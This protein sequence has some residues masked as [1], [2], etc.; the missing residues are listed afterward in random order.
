MHPKGFEMIGSDNVS[1]IARFNGKVATIGAVI[2][3]RMPPVAG[4]RVPNPSLFGRQFAPPIT[5]HKPAA[6]VANT[7]T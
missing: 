3:N 1:A 2:D 4:M 7:T 6:W 5:M